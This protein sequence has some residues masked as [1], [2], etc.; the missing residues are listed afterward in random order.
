MI[1]HLVL[2]LCLLQA[3]KQP[4]TET[5]LLEHVPLQ[6]ERPLAS[7]AVKPM[8]ENRRG[9]DVSPPSLQ[10]NDF[11]FSLLLLAQRAAAVPLALGTQT[12]RQTGLFQAKP[13]ALSQ[14]NLYI[15]DNECL[16]GEA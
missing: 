4:H 2:P 1:T 11:C 10:D 14:W 15:F 16:K 7:P 12:H 3:R 13:H 8:E 5:A 9:R 6:F